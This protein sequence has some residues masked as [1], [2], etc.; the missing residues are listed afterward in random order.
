MP[1][2]QRGQTGLCLEQLAEGL[3]VLKS[4]FIGDLANSKFL[5][6]DRFSLAS[7]ISLSWRCCCVLCPVRDLSTPY[8]T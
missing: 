1:E 2:F 8:T 3:Q 5:V 6:V 4:Q 7:S